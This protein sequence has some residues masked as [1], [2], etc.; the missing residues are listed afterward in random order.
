MLR[1]VIFDTSSSHLGLLVQWNKKHMWGH[2]GLEYSVSIN[3]LSGEAYVSEKW[4]CDEKSATCQKIS[5]V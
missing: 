4:T 5:V 3:I 1:T 2:R